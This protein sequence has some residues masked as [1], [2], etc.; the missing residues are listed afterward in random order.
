VRDSLAVRCAAV[1]AVSPL[2]TNHS[3]CGFTTSPVSLPVK[4]FRE[5]SG[6]YNSLLAAMIASIY[7]A[8]A[9][10]E[11]AESLNRLLTSASKP[12]DLTKH[13]Q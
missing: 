8:P 11:R 2:L 4:S 5:P 10:C 1:V 9:T 7:L 6:T 3:G 13:S 12:S